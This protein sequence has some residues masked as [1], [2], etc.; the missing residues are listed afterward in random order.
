MQYLVSSIKFQ[1]NSCLFSR[2]QGEISTGQAHDLPGDAES[3]SASVFFGGEEGNKYMF[4]NVRGDGR[5]IVGYFNQ[6]SFGFIAIG[7]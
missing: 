1:Y 5:T 3:Y 6:Y 7:A 2:S 4:G